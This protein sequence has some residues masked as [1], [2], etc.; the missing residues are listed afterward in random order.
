MQAIYV[1]ALLV[2]S[3]LLTLAA[4]PIWQ[5]WLGGR[6]ADSPVPSGTSDAEGFDA[7][8]DLANNN[9]GIALIAI[10]V[11]LLLAGLCALFDTNL[12]LDP[13]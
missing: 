1:G 11:I 4:P 8:F 3:G 2:L 12:A 6:S 9:P 13:A 5:D 7:G 10:G